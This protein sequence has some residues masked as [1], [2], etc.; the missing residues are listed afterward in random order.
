M[1]IDVV[2]IELVT[3]SKID[4]P[5]FEEYVYDAST[6]GKIFARLIGHC[7]V[8]NV[9]IICINS[10]NKILNYST[11]AIGNSDNVS[12]SVAQIFKTILLSNAT[13]FIIAHNHPSGVLEATPQDIELT[14]NVGAISKL[15]GITFID[16]LIVNGKEEIYSIREH[17]N[18]YNK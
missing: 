7:N 3:K 2:Q 12:I 17:L 13:K 1:T 9:G 18:E 15:F 11:L 8:E 4:L 10:G 6:A 16:S 5:N 14:K